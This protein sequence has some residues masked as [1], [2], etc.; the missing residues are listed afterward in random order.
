MKRR[1]QKKFREL[2][3]R[4]MMKKNGNKTLKF[5]KV[6]TVHA[7]CFSL[8][9]SP[10]AF[11]VDTSN[12]MNT[13]NAGLQM[14]GSILTQMQSQ[15]QSALKQR[16]ASAQLNS[17]Q[18]QM[19]PSK[20]FPQCP[21][22]QGVSNFPEGACEPVAAGD[23]D[24]ANKLSQ[25]QSL[26]VSYESFFENLM[27]EGQN[28]SSPVGLQCILEATKKTDDQLQDM[29]N[30]L[31]AMINKIAKQNQ[32]FKQDI[33]DVREQ[34]DVIGN[35]LYGGKDGDN[36]SESTS[37]ISEF[38]SAC[39]TYLGTYGD[40]QA[41]G[42]GLVSLRDQT[43]GAENDVAGKFLN[44]RSTYVA[45]VKSQLTALKEE[46]NANGLQ[47]LDSTES[48]QN[49][50][51]ASGSSQQFGAMSTILKAKVNNLK[52]DFSSIQEDL[53]AVGFDVAFDDLDG[54]FQEQYS[55]FSTGAYEYF[56]KEAVTDCVTGSGSVINGGLS[57]DQILAGLRSKISSGSGTSLDTYRQ[58]L[59]NILD[60]DAFI[61]DKL[62]AISQLDS[63]YGVGNIYVQV[64]DSTAQNVS[65]TPYG[66]Y[67]KQIELCEAKIEQDDTFST[68]SSKRASGSSS[69][70]NRIAKAEKAI[71]KALALETEYQNEITDALYDR[72]V[73]C[74]GVSNKPSA[75]SLSEGGSDVATFL[76]PS[77][78]NFCIKD[79]TTCASKVNSCYKEADKIVTK[80]KT[81]MEALAADY[82]AK[83]SAV[84]ANQE[85][86]L[87]QIKAQVVNQ[88]EFIKQY[89]PGSSYVFPE[90]LF[91]ELPEEEM[92][93]DLGVA[94]RGGA[95]VTSLDDLETKLGSLKDML[96]EQREKVQNEL[97]D[98]YAAQ[99]QNM[100]DEMAK[101]SQL[102]SECVAAIDQYNAEVNAAN[103]QTAETYNEALSFC[104]KYNAMATNPA[105]GCGD[106][107]SL[108]ESAME[109]SS[110][111]LA[112]SN[113]VRGQVMAY[114]NHCNEA[115]NEG[116]DKK[117]SSENDDRSRT[118][119]S[120]NNTVIAMEDTCKQYEDKD[121]EKEMA[122][123]IKS[124][125]PADFTDEEKEAVE[126]ALEK[127]SY[128][129]PRLSYDIR[130]STFFTNT[131]QPF[132]DAL[133]AGSSNKLPTLPA[134]AEDA[135]DAEKTKYNVVKAKWEEFDL[136]KTQDQ[137]DEMNACKRFKV[138][139]EIALVES[140]S[141]E[142]NFQ[143]CYDENKVQTSL[144]DN[145][146]YEAV[147]RAIAS[148][149]DSA[150]SSQ[151]GRI[152]EQMLG[153]PCMA[154]QGNNGAAGFDVNSFDSANLSS[155][156]AALLNSMQ[157]R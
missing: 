147:T 10:M 119:T 132:I 94:L 145:P 1:S 95:Q 89:L 137:W 148:I 35:Q 109:V 124:L 114:K 142:S 139:K 54:D 105:A 20:Y 155:T 18:P 83:V 25:Y 107:D 157:S 15:Q 64:Q 17:L 48:L 42:S 61:E 140:C 97:Q 2:S 84:I 5:L 27:S 38:S 151:S 98:Y 72:V 60:S 131:L 106:V 76:E 13:I 31:Q 30:N 57:T 45:Q 22:A 126:N 51:I 120:K 144:A 112:N 136:E 87:N 32:T 127:G 44:D 59:K 121:F 85:I 29:I 91:V 24:G 52:R 116:K 36:N 34:M 122:A 65:M 63:R 4:S 135:T 67:Q 88:A 93:N 153:T 26:A 108:Y 125:I 101:W 19:V 123:D 117:D 7:S 23:S 62:S 129:E 12:T 33:K 75:C 69:Y 71:K 103:A 149:Q 128:Q 134:L 74:T 80:K 143:E 92:V 49:V 55:D 118:N 58:A 133:S 115:N 156:A 154:Q 73:N 86:L 11:A 138:S 47:A 43:I 81:Q 8:L 9:S 77:S 16:L 152:G 70:S 146:E 68:D 110:Q 82:N 39:Q 141:G 99:A 130:S 56:K 90:D 111:Y 100:G 79:A 46:I 104:Q 96:T 66:L 40:S 102:K 37:L 14:A 3:E 53:S 113:E 6:V 50:L 21:V 78:A 41:K 28:S 150:T